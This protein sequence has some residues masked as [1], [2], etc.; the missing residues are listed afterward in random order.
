MKS[1]IQNP[2]VPVF[3][4]LAFLLMCS[5]G[6]DHANA[7]VRVHGLFTNN[8]I[9]QQGMNVP[10]WGWADPGEKITVALDEQRAVTEADMRGTWRVRL[11]PFTAD[12]RTLTL[13]I[14]GKN[15]IVLH[16]V[17]IG[18]V[19]LA[20]GQ[21]N[22]D[23]ELYPSKK[24]PWRKGVLDYEREIS[25]A[26]Y[27]RMRLYTCPAK[28]AP[29]PLDNCSGTWNVCTPETVGDFSAVAYF[30]G[31]DIHVALDVPVG[32]IKSSFGGS[33]IESWMS[34]SSLRQAGFDT[35]VEEWIGFVTA[36]DHGLETARYE[37]QLRKYKEARITG[38]PGQKPRP[39]LPPS[40]HVNG[41]A[42]LYNGMIA[43]LM[44]F[45][46]RGTIWYQGESNT[47]NASDYCT[48][49]PAL[50][51]SWRSA[52]NQGAVP[53]L[54]VQLANYDDKDN[55]THDWP[56]VRE[57][58]RQAL[59]LPD[60]AMVVTLDVGDAQ[61]I[62][63]RNKKPVG[64]RLARAA[65]ALAYDKDII[66]SGPA[67]RSMTING[68][69]VFLHFD[70]ASG[71]LIADNPAPLYGFE[72]AGIDETFYP[73][74]AEIDGQSVVV[75][76]DHVLDPASVRYAWDDNPAVSIVRNNQGLPASPFT[77][78]AWCPAHPTKN[79][80]FIK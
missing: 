44:P 51:K 73:A 80:N 74:T 65:Q 24:Y 53:F 5:S 6:T 58:Q 75:R 26:N 34:L 54:F 10:V 23:M 56:G 43:P 17:L 8:M 13:T 71:G 70:H 15:T 57:A 50:I 33:R 79:K 61:N 2:L 60:T 38:T 42:H 78:D 69:N 66:F 27:P 18:E 32:L 25:R 3:L 19:W 47:G 20:S 55:P 12:N 30:F 64:K 22:M 72:I 37:E 67:Y 68:D 77:T 59:D 9:V 41:P 49:F 7:D 36:Y 14:S 28:T 31:R 1:S 45:A 46:L 63:P 11:G 29:H 21:S 48:L 39:P 62:H 16:N 4:F 52:W 76:S 35:I 40:R